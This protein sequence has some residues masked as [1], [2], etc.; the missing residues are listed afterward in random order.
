MAVVGLPDD[1]LGER[2]CA[3]VILEDEAGDIT[4]GE[5]SAC[6]SA[7][8]LAS[9]KIPDEV[10]PVSAFPLTA[11]GKTDKRALTLMAS[12]GVGDER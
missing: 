6:L 11:V 3:F 5:V 4:R 8:G 12:E 1:M 10:R 9:F 2:I 7:K